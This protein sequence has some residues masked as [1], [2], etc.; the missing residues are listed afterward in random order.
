[1]KRPSIYLAGP[2]VFLP[3]AVE[4]G[5]RKKA[6]CAQYGFTGLFPF[7]NDPGVATGA[8]VDR[9]IYEANVR[10]IRR[11]DLGI[12]NLT[13]FRGPSADVGTV[14][15][16]G[17]MTGLKKPAIGYT[18]CA[19]SLRER[20]PGATRTASGEWRDTDG[21]SV[22]DFGNA[23]NLMIDACLSQPGNTLIRCDAG[24]SL[25]GL[26]AFERCLQFAAERFGRAPLVAV[27]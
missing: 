4:T 13:P 27:G 12:F 15:E 5:R 11:A 17:L 23:D 3:D 10:M 18:N 9:V 8:A 2:D 7:D 26:D 19:K 20:V 16:L 6:L 22:E 25:G 1:V 14:F 24:G 21:N